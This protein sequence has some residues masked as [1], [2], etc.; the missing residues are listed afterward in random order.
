MVDNDQGDYDSGDCRVCSHVV[1]VVVAM[2][3][4]TV[5]KVVIKVSTKL[6]TDS[7]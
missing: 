1:H 5:T 7:L 6:M 2:V 4:I 3:Y